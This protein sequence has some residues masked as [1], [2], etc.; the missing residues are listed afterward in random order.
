MIPRLVCIK[1]EKKKDKYIASLCDTL[2]IPPIAVYRISPE[3]KEF[4]ISQIR[5]IQTLIM[6]ATPTGRLIVLSEFQTASAEA[7]NALL[8]ALEESSDHNCFLL[9]VN[10]PGDVLP[11]IQSRCIVVPNHQ[12]RQEKVQQTTIDWSKIPLYQYSAN[13]VNADD[14]KVIIERS[15]EIVRSMLV[16]SPFLARWIKKAIQTVYLI[17]KNNINPLLAIDSLTIQLR[18]ILATHKKT[19]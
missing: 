17:E 5:A 2:R 11:T 4:S 10:H 14:A 19:I 3:K 13:P 6:S 16:Q 12:E 15:I 18:N 9:M 7:Q 1:D 8:K